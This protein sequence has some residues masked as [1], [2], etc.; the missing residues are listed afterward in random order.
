MMSLHAR[1]GWLPLLP[2]S[3]LLALSL[4]MLVLPDIV[5]LDLNIPLT[6]RPLTIS[7]PFNVSYFP[8]NIISLSFSSY[9]F[10]TWL[11]MN[12]QVSLGEGTSN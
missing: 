9:C 8:F 3:S 7:I 4:L 10:F 11:L 2:L 1:H 5:D 6:L 12:F